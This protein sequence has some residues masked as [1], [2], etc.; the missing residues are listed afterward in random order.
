MHSTHS[1]IRSNTCACFWHI[2]CEEFLSPTVSPSKGI[3]YTKKSH[4][5]LNLNAEVLIANTSIH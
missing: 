1:V 4:T 5:A 3:N 2:S